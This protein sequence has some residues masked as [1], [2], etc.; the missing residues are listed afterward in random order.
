LICGGEVLG[1]RWFPREPEV[2]MDTADYG[3]GISARDGMETVDED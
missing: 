1:E 2:L 3:S